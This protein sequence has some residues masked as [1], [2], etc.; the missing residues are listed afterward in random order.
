MEKK[1]LAES[2]IRP[3]GMAD[4]ALDGPA[5]FERGIVED[6]STVCVIQS[7]QIAL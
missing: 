6:A 7:L 4:H 1:R 5:N 2:C 3:D